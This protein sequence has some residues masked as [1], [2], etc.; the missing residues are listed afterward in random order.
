[1]HNA[2]VEKVSLFR[3]SLPQILAC[4]AKN[5]LMV[6]LGLALG[7]S[8]IAIPVL[9]GL[10]SDRYPNETMHFTAEEASWFG[11]LAFMTQPIGSIVSGWITEQIGRKRAMLVVNVP[12]IIGWAMLYY[13]QTNTVLFVA[14]VLMGLGVGLMESPIMTYVGE[15]SHP[16]IRGPLLAFSNLAVMFGSFAMYLLGTVFTW[17]QCALIGFFVPIITIIAILFVNCTPFI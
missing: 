17:R 15:I 2:D 11:S 14:G 5:L 12:H 13:A 4:S 16:S 9:L 7:F 10:Q 3:R 8:T 1:M 6:D